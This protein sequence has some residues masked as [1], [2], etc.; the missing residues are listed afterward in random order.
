MQT[1][2]NFV[3][4]DQLIW[5][6]YVSVADIQA[7]YRPWLIE[8]ITKSSSKLLQ[9]PTAVKGWYCDYCG[10]KPICTLFGGTGRV[11][12]EKSSQ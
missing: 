6:K 7:V 11:A 1:A 4:T 2:I 8:Y 3:Q 10:Y 9:A 5:N 12:D